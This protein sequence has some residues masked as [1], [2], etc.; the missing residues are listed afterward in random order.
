MGP[1]LKGRAPPFGNKSH[2]EKHHNLWRWG[3]LCKQGGGPRPKLDGRKYDSQNCRNFMLHISGGNMNKVKVNTYGVV[4]SVRSSLHTHVPLLVQHQHPLFQ[5]S[6]RPTAFTL[7]WYNV[8]YATQGSAHN[9]RNNNNKKHVT[10]NKL[11][12]LEATLV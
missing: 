12:S 4:S 7:N 1:Y 6:V 9:S 3:G 8:I 11:A 2:R 5:L 10:R